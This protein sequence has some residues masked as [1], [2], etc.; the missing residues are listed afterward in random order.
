[1]SGDDPA[2]LDVR[3]RW[4]VYYGGWPQFGE[5]LAWTYTNLGPGNGITRYDPTYAQGSS[6]PGEAVY[7]NLLMPSVGLEVKPHPRV[8][9]KA[10]WSWLHADQ[11]APGVDDEIGT[12]A[13]LF[14]QV[15][16]LEEPRVQ[17]LRRLHRP[18]QGAGRRRRPAAPGVRRRG[19]DVLMAERRD[20]AARPL[21][22]PPAPARRHLDLGR[23]AR[24][25]AQRRL[26]AGLDVDLAGQGTG[27][28][29]GGALV[30]HFLPV[31]YNVVFAVGAWR[32]AGRP[33]HSPR[34]GAAARAIALGLSR[35][36]W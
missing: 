3:E 12:Y 20:R 9:A 6:V 1:M 13:Q 22:R 29:R 17:P 27:P 7:S 5:H 26:H 31:P 18:R 8:T 24:R 15:H 21:G 32:A 23:P 35:C 10:S 34:G 11:T 2:T 30:I 33:E 19:A 14:S 25:P 36:T 4:D 16:L 28:A